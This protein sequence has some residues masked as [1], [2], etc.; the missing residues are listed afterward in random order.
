MA[1]VERLQLEAE[2]RQAIAN[3]ELELHYQPTLA[4]ATGEIVGLEALARWKHPTRG[5]VPPSEFIPLAEQTGLI[6]RL[7]RW[8]LE[9]ACCR[10]VEWQEQF[11]AYRKL[12]VS[13]NISGRHMED[14][15][16]ID[17]VQAAL[18][19][20]GLEPG[21]LV[22][23]M[24]ESVLMAHTEENV[25]L[26]G[27]LKALGVGLAIDDFGT[28][29]SSLAY[30]HRFPADVIKIDRSFIERLGSSESDA[31]L[32]RT[33]VQLG[34]S[35]RMVAVAEGIETAEQ[36]LA[37]QGMGCELAQGFYFHRALAVGALQQLLAPAEV[38]ARTR[39]RA[40]A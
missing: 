7:G 18:A 25:E 27:R 6:R 30:L 1:L 14:A 31:E 29:Y 20:S 3:D 4:L 2:L 39:R 22:L 13:V 16:L 11:P 26:L 19:M 28:G 12:T 32:L 35:L 23:E 24:T 17:D 33:I 37:L 5:F 10:L 40:A 36:A 21:H 15:S 34:Q 38:P 8:G 9:E